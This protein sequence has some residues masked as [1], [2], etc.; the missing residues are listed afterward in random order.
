MITPIYAENELHGAPIDNLALLAANLDRWRE[1]LSPA[2]RFDP[3][4]E[5]MPTPPPHVLSLQ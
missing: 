2:V 1:T 3:T 4:D 5:M